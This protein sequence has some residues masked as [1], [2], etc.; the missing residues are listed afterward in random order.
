MGYVYHARYT[1][2]IPDGDT[3]P[4][5]QT[6]DT[7]FLVC[8]STAVFLVVVFVLTCIIINQKH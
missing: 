2:T 8:F 7:P 6:G 3:T 4:E 1:E 5:I